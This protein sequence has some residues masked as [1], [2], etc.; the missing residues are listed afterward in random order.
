MRYALINPPWTFDGSI[1]FGCRQPH[2]PLEYGYAKTLLETAGHEVLLLD[3]QLFDRSFDETAHAVHDF[4]PDF[5]VVCTAPSYLFWRCAPP[6]LR[7][8]QAMIRA[9]G[10][11]GGCI[12]GVGPHCSTTPKTALRKLAADIV[13]MGECEEI[14]PQL[15]G[16]WSQA[17]SVCYEIGGT[18]WTQG[19]T[20]ATDMAALPALRWDSSLIER[21]S[22]HHHRFDA[23]PSGHGAE[24][25]T[26]R[27]CP[28]HCTFCAKDNFRDKYRRRPVPAV[29]E[30]IDGLLA[31][32]VE[33]IY[34]ID[35]IFLPNQELLEGLAARQLKC[36]IQTRLDLWNEAAIELL[37]RAGCVSI[38][39]GVESITVEGRAALD[40]KCRMSTESLADKLLF[41]RSHVPFVQANLIQMEQDH[42]AEVESFRQRLIANGVWANQP[43]PLFPYP[44][45]PDYTNRWGAPDASAWERATDY[46]LDMY[47]RFSDIQEERPLSLDQ[48]E[49]AEGPRA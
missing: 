41:A 38:E 13:V 5:S 48:L 42:P 2:L 35:E 7:V 14:L 27:G 46:Y 16:P 37:G 1:Y 20:H 9:L 10:N 32:G 23:E 24:V 43:V 34:F 44:G 4:R 8:P 47:D 11:R 21:H 26:S 39:A 29:L 31:Q 19:T 33:Y 6:E 45:S 18:A 28:Y 3:A 15:S 49:V 25:E 22:H 40:K 12:V 17:A 36:G 30:E